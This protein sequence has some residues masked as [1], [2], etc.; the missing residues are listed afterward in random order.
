MQ[1]HKAHT[2][3]QI[4]KPTGQTHMRSSPEIDVSSFVLVHPLGAPEERLDW[5]ITSVLFLSHFMY[6][7][8]VHLREI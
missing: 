5:G 4:H 1:V 7:E 2:H 6:K 8:K 3:K